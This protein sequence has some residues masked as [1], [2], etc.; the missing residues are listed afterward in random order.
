MKNKIIKAVIIVFVSFLSLNAQ[1]NLQKGK[2]AITQGDYVSAVG[3]LENAVKVEKNYETYYY[4]GL[5]LY[6]TG[7]LKQAEDNLKLAL[8]DDDEGIHAMLTLGSLYSQQKKYQ[9]ADNIFKKAAKIAPENVNVLIAQADNYSLQGKIDEAIKVLTLATTFSK[10]N[11]NVYIGLGDAYRIRG[12]YKL[13]N[14]Y[15]KKALALKKIPAA[16]T[17]LGDSYFRMKKY[18]E[19]IIEY[20]NAIA[21]DPNFAD[22]YLGKGKIL[23]FGGKYGD[24]AESFQKY[25]QLMPGSQE[26]NSYFAKTLF[27][28]GDIFATRGQMDLAN[29]KFD[30][31]IKILNNVLTVDPKSITGNLFMAYTYTQKAFIDTANA[32]TY[33]NKAIEYFKNVD[34]KDYEIEDL[35]KL[36]KLYVTQKNF[37]EAHS[38]FEKAEKMDSTYVELYR[39][40]GKAYFREGKFRDA[41]LKAVKALELG[42]D[43]TYGHFYLAITLYADAKYIESVP[44]FQKAIELD[45]SF[46]LAKE[47]LA[48][49]YRFGNK[50]DEAIKA[51]EEVLKQDP[52][53][54]EA[55]DMIKALN[56]K[57]GSN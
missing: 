41:Y 23:Y 24:A 8:K 49:A 44:S 2:N 47:F 17:G 48:R 10:D 28:Q 54:Q 27:K 51:Y 19:A 31:A 34:S 1:D 29:E 7:S 30:E 6:K 13:A 56:A 46:L 43:D 20:D 55:I 36:A 21:L 33:Q 11:P 45:P 18:N 3:F 53:N 14:D 37:S 39:E 22:A 26:G 50:I 4:Y 32:E 38:I 57:K 15:Y 52:A 5:A 16:Y 9:E 25:S 12:S 42:G 40:W 35:L